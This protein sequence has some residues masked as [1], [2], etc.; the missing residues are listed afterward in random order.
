MKVKPSKTYYI[1]T[2]AMKNELLYSCI[3]DIQIDT[4][5]PFK[6]AQWQLS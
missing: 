3:F 4:H 5:D 6:K 1:T 2:E